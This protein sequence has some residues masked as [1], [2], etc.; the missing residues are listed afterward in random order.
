MYLIHVSKTKLISSVRLCEKKT[1][2][3][4]LPYLKKNLETKHDPVDVSENNSI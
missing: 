4:I 3:N 1:I 2:G